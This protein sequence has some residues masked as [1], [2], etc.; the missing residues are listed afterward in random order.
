MFLYYCDSF[1]WV[2]LL[3][4]EVVVFSRYVIDEEVEVWVDDGIFLFVWVG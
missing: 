2:I 3:V 4:R 1:L